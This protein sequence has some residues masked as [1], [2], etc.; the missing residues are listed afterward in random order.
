[1]VC[2]GLCHVPLKSPNLYLVYTYR[3]SL[4]PSLFLR[5]QDGQQICSNRAPVS[6][7][8]EKNSSY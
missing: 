3:E 6:T 8:L 1:M 2:A 7:R 4:R 5:L